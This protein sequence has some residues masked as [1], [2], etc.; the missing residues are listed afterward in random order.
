MA[1]NYAY[2][3]TGCGDL[4]IVDVTNP[5]SPTQIG[6]Y[7]SAG[8]ITAVDGNYAYF[9]QDRFLNIIDV[10]DPVS[11]TRACFY[12]LFQDHVRDLDIAENSTGTQ[13]FAYVANAAS[14]LRILDVTNPVSPTLIGSYDVPEQEA[15]NGVAIEGNFAF[16]A[17]GSHNYVGGFNGV[18]IIDVSNPVA[19]VE[20]GHYDTRDSAV[21]V[22]VVGNY[23]YV[24]ERGSDG[25]FSGLQVIDVSNP[26]SPEEVGFLSMPG[27]PLDV[28]VV[29]NYTY[30]TAWN[31]GLAILQFRY[32]PV[33]G[34]IPVDGGSLIA[35]ADHT[36]YTFPPHAFTETVTITHTAR[37]LRNPP[38]LENDLADIG[39]YFDVTG[40]YSNTKQPVVFAPGQVAT[41]TVQ[42][43]DAERG[44]VIE[45]TL[46][47]YYWDGT[48]WV[49]EP[50]SIV[51]P[52]HK[53][54]TATLNHSKWAVLGETERRFL[55]LV[56][57]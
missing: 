1:G 23:A 55:P 53:S 26:T 49:K 34:V 40:V 43:T 3:S 20:V 36:T 14:G 6:F 9:R 8:A 47:L 27:K 42:Y 19:P 38:V 29:G 44:S 57:R 45:S 52:S 15:S 12:H 18:R 37:L 56:S 41:V 7:P 21:D 32:A 35:Y 39:H 48:K 30:V 11:P 31:R 5:V 22:E 16:V 2:Y 33:S 50:S 51:D 4:H 17:E 25:K 10:T 28:E 54:T 46:G 24:A 13:R